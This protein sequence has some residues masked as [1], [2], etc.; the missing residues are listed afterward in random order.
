[1]DKTKQTSESLTALKGLV[2]AFV[3]A[4]ITLK[5]KPDMI[6]NITKILWGCFKTKDF[7]KACQIVFE[8][9]NGISFYTAYLKSYYEDNGF[10]LRYNIRKEKLEYF[11]SL[12]GVQS[13]AQW[14][15]EVSKARKAKQAALDP[16]SRIKAAFDKRLSNLSKNDLLALSKLVKDKINSKV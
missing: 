14:S 9:T 7:E 4:R 13:Y 11:G 8:K 16:D 10:I 6:D 12:E 15:D 1:M 3:N 5:N 2:S